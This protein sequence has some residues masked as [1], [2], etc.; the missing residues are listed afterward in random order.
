MLDQVR[1]RGL[2]SAGANAQLLLAEG[3]VLHAW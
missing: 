1:S 3:R 2:D